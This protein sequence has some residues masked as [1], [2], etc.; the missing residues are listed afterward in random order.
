VHFS[1]NLPASVFL[2][3]PF[4][5]DFFLF[6]DAFL[7]SVPITQCVPPS[8]LL[9]VSCVFPLQPFSFALADGR[10]FSGFQEHLVFWPTLL[11]LPS[12]A[13]RFVA[14]PLLVLR[15]PFFFYPSH[16]G[17]FCVLIGLTL[18]ALWLFKLNGTIVGPLLVAKGLPPLL[19]RGC[20]FL[21]K[22]ASHGL[23]SDLL[24]LY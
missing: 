6:Y 5:P 3:T 12:A 19:V 1:H 21:A 4:P 13:A 23:F 15:A 8:T 9:P 2:P 7:P 10:F 14:F 17:G 16:W 24:V 18:L 20:S 11:F 22:Y